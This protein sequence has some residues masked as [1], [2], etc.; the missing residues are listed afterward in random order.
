MNLRFIGCILLVAGTCIGAGLLALPL[1][2]AAGGFVNTSA[3]LFFCWIVTLCGSYYM[4]EVN[5][6]LPQGTNLVSMAKATLGPA[7]ALI[8]WLAYLLLL[9]ALMAAYM[10]GGTDITYT[11]LNP[12]I[13]HLPHWIDTLL[14][15]AVFVF[16]I[17]TGIRSV[18]RA[19]RLLMII[20]LSSFFFLLFLLV[21]HVQAP[22]L[23]RGHAPKLLSALMIIV[24]SF[25]FALIIPSLRVYLKSDVKQLRLAI[26]FGSLLALFCYGTWAMAIQGIIAIPAL[27]AIAAS[28]HSVTNLT[29]SLDHHFGNAGITITTHIFASVA[30]LTAFLAVGL[31][32]TDFLADGFGLK[33]HGKG[34][35]II[36]A[37][38]F[39]PPL[40]IVFVYPGIFIKALS[41]A[42]IA[43]V[44]LFITLPALMALQQRKKPGKKDTY[45]FCGGNKLLYFTLIMS[46]VFLLIG[47]FY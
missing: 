16:I 8:T 7:G 4:L 19:N 39:I 47:V 36:I 3:V 2:T 15:T 43:C 14:F 32:L 42:G 20:K 28:P 5:L 17:Y 1:A 12:F 18:D 9:Y 11:Y 46:V 35:W 6:R 29:A 37:S 23:T 26:A 40:L 33:K 22:L 30:I 41:Y 10:A 45:Y 24:T 25:G 31:S 34:Q 13:G 38:A 27:N 44:I 21:P